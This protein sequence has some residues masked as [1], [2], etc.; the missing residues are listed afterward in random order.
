MVNDEKLAVATS[1]TH[2]ENSQ[3]VKKTQL[4]CF[5]KS[6]NIYSYSVAMP[7][8]IDFALL[9]NINYIIRQL[10]EFGLIERWDKY[11]RSIA[12]NAIILDTLKAGDDAGGGHLVVLTV[13]H[14]TGA[15]L[16][17][18]LG[19]TVAFIAFLIEQIVSRRIESGSRRKIWTRLHSMLSQNRNTNE[20]RLCKKSL[21]IKLYAKRLIK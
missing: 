7:V 14:V 21:F 6:D 20:N 9:P 3:I 11:S 4:Y 8:K 12:A 17:M 19:H 1:R 18:S 15:I 2:A 16:V 13:A 5:S 10:F